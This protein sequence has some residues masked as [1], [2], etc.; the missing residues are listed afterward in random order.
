MISCTPLLVIS[1][2]LSIK[3]SSLWGIYEG[4]RRLRTFNVGRFFRTWLAVWR[5][6]S[7]IWRLFEKL[8]ARFYWNVYDWN[9]KLRFFKEVSLPSSLLIF[10]TAS[11][12]SWW[13]LKVSL[14][15]YIYLLI[16]APKL[17]SRV[18]NCLSI[19]SVLPRI[20]NGASVSRSLL[21]HKNGKF[22]DITPQS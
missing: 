12:V 8:I 22:R 4:K 19:F 10:F 17:S 16:Y 5:V 6:T 20:K 13:Q 3:T 14:K 11:S 2:H 7:V 1:G 15:S 18:C 21:S 9:F